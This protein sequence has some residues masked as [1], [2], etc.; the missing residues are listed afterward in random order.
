MAHPDPPPDHTPATGICRYFRPRREYGTC[1]NSAAFPFG[2]FT[3]LVI[4]RRDLNVGLPSQLLHGANVTARVQ[5][6]GNEG[7]AKIVW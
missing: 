2:D 1:N 3:T 6:I 5:L 4:P 7:P